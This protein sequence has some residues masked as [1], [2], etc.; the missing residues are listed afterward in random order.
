MNITREQGG[1]ADIVLFQQTTGEALQPKSKTTMGRY[2]I[3]VDHQVAFEM[4]RI[5]TSG[6]HFVDLLMVIVDSLAACRDFQTT[7]QQVETAGRLWI[8][9]VV[10]RIE[11]T[12]AAEIV[13]DEDQLAARIFQD[14]L[15]VACDITHLKID[16]GVFVQMPR[17]VMLLGSKNRSDFMWISHWVSERSSFTTWPITMTQVSSGT[18]ARSKSE[19]SWL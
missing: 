9:F 11:R 18:T 5:H 1:I 19:N 13:G 17:R 7:E 14:D 8:L 2:A 4:I 16:A 3:L 6:Q 10:H 15:Y 12:L